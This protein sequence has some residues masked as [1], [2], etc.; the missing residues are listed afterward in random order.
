MLARYRVMMNREPEELKWVFRYGD[1]LYKKGRR[2]EAMA[3]FK[4]VDALYARRVSAAPGSVTPEERAF[5]AQARFYRAGEEMAAFRKITIRGDKIE[6]ALIQ[7]K[8]KAHQTVEAA[9]LE[10]A[11]YASPRWTIA[12]L[13]MA[14]K[15][16][17]EIS[18][19]FLEA[20]EPKGLDLAQRQQYRQLVEDKVRPYR[21]K[22][23]QYRQAALDKAH[24]VGIFCP[25][26][27]TCY[28]T[29][30]DGENPPAIGRD[31][32]RLGRGEGAPDESPDVLQQ[33]L[34]EDPGNTSLLR[35]L[36]VAY[37]EQGKVDLASLVLTRCLEK[38]PEDA[39]SQ[40]LLGLI[41]LLRSED[42]EAY[43]LFQKVLEMDP[44]MDEARANLVVLN[45]GYGNFEKAR[46]SLLEIVDRQRLLSAS[47]S[48]VHPDFLAAA[49]RLEIVALDDSELEALEDQ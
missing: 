37:A 8:I 24:N 10:V 6:N 29:L 32:L 18:R 36:A 34:Y 22:A 45:E 20:P 3:T 43:G 44:A 41:H 30:N 14:A 23:T 17:D 13:V 2:S 12:S 27:I 9:G 33:G 35:S 28:A 16:N 39:Q 15:A 40:N 4:K 7:K 42:Q 47:A 11:Q 48:S 21:E 19:F 25:E 46:I 38:N 49:G 1:T 5:A 31:S 26:V